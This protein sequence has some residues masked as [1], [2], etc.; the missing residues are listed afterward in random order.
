MHNVRWRSGT[1]CPRRLCVQSLAGAVA[2]EGARKIVH[3]NEVEIERAKRLGGVSYPKTS[4][5]G[6]TAVGGA[7]REAVKRLRPRPLCC[8]PNRVP[9]RASWAWWFG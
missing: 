8:R 3:A 9:Y 6:E 2:T 7:A 5:N 1:T 4:G